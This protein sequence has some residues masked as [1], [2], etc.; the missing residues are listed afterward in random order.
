MASFRIKNLNFAYKIDGKKQKVL[1]DINLD[2]AK[3]EFTAIVGP[4]GSGKSTLLHVMGCLL[5]ADS[6]QVLLGGHDT[7]KLGVDEQ[8]AIRS[9]VLGF[10]FQ[11]F[12]L[13]PRMTVLDNILLPLECSPFSMDKKRYRQSAVRIAD[14]LGISD[15]L[16]KLPNQLSGGQQQRV[17][18]AR[19]LLLNPQ[20]ILADEPTGNLDSKSSFEIL[21]ILREL[22]SEGVT[23]VIITH[24]REIADSCPRKIS[25]KD[26]KITED[27]GAPDHS[28]KEQSSAKTPIT[29][30]TSHGSLKTIFSNLRRNKLRSFL[31]MLGVTIGI[32]SVLAMT[33]LGE[34]TK[35][36][37]L[38]TYETLGV[39]KLS[40]WGHRN[41]QLKATDKVQNYFQE[42][43]VD[44][45]L[46]HLKKIFPEVR[47]LSPTISHWNMNAAYGGKE[48]DRVSPL[49]VNHEYLEI[50]NAKVILG[51]PLSSR[52]VDLETPVCVI[53]YEVF[54]HLFRQSSPIGKNLFIQNDN[55]AYGCRVL[56]VLDHQ[57]SNE[58]WFVP[59]KQILLPF[60]FLRN[61]GSPWDRWIDSA[62]ATVAK[63]HDVEETGKKVRN[64]F[65]SKYGKSGNFRVSQDDI[66][67]SQ[68]KKFLTV[69]TLLL[70]SIAIIALLIGGI[71]L[72]N[73]MLVSVAE[74][75]REI[76]VRKAI[77]AT[78]SSIRRQFLGESVILCLLAGIVG[79][80]LGVGAYEGI[81][82]GAAQAFDSIEFK[83]VFEPYSF[84]LSFL[85]IVAVGV[86]SGI[87]PAIKAERLQIVEALRSE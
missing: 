67:V 77:G 31:T 62:V 36:N 11:Q 4:S 59:D 51:K 17:A 44:H 73:M 61:F 69:F 9:K 85:C 20:V 66:L 63:G 38:E 57:S 23:V 81:I 39:N 25:I 41:W 27:T 82:W 28:G 72:A 68:A 14:R 76:G 3:G 53:G 75:Y 79:L 40:F 58:G 32:A 15:L 13:I 50:T 71:G 12:H 21:K 60:T 1:D 42:F 78:N 16:S 26:G 29:G 56:G 34:Y 33:T 54:K 35:Q 49:G 47:L 65:E 83:W 5:Y 22:N 52:H 70:G 6:G 19:S 2:I 24:D 48:L 80:A 37:I 87:I 30:R 46:Y 55:T 8:A 64:Y 86:A 43:S 10:I 84:T 18:I 74:R 7:Q 45:D